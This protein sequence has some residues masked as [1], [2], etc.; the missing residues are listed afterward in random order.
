M[1]FVVE[2]EDSGGGGGREGANATWEEVEDDGVDSE[3]L[4]RAK[5][6]RRMSVL[7]GDLDLRKL[8]SPKRSGRVSSFPIR[9]R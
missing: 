9:R 5:K 8:E 1:R 4:E 3:L 7:R 6:A 2:A